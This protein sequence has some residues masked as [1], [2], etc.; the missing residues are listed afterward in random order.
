MIAPIPPDTHATVPAVDPVRQQPADGRPADRPVGTEAPPS[1]DRVEISAAAR[2][3]AGAAP[4]ASDADVEAARVALRSESDLG[5][6]R[7]H[8]LRERVRTGY[9][10]RP[11]ALDQ[12]AASVAS[13]LAGS[14]RA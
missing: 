6:A 5:P 10:D 3:Q 11:E 12:L 4:E 1:R 7:L 13:D 8:E 9:Y 2:A 14:D